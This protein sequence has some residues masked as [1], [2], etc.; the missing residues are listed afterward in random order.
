MGRFFLKLGTRLSFM[1]PKSSSENIYLNSEWQ[2]L[3]YKIGISGEKMSEAINGA[4]PR[5]NI[6][7]Q[8]CPFGLYA[9]QLSGTSFTTPRVSN[10]RIWFYRILPSV[11]H[12]PLKRCGE[13]LLISNFSNAE[14]IPNQTRWN[15]L[16]FPKDSESIDFI[17]GL[18]TFAGNNQP[19]GECGLAIHLCSCNISMIKKAFCN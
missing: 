14:I 3:K 5:T 9:E 19:G 16:P 10:Q 4:V 6:N 18:I 1:K 17:R 11:K 12:G 7:P 15:P 8:K 2:R 13:G